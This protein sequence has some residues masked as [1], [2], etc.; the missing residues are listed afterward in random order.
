[1]FYQPWSNFIY[2]NFAR[3]S[4][5]LSVSLL[6][7]YLAALL[8][9]VVMSSFTPSGFKPGCI[10]DCIPATSN[11]Y[12]LYGIPWFSLAALYCYYSY[13]ICFLWF[14]C[15]KYYL[16]CY[17]IVFPSSSVKLLRVKMTTWS[18]NFGVNLITGLRA[19][20]KFMRRYN[21]I[22]IGDTY[23]SKS[24]IKLSAKLSVWSFSR[25]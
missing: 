5:S 9:F 15:I 24:S 18:L 22:S 3:R 25:K 7:S 8:S 13:L 20:Y 6:L 12:L 1:M 11:F 19:N 14:S 10:S 16:S 23:S 21:V 4:I 2:S 17:L